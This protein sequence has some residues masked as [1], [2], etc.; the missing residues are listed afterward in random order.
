MRKIFVAM[1]LAACGEENTKPDAG[2]HH[3]DAHVVTV[4]DA[5]GIWYLTTAFDPGGCNFTS[6]PPDTWIFVKKPTGGY[7]ITVSNPGPGETLS[8]TVVDQRGACQL[9]MMDMVVSGNL[10]GSRT[11]N[12]TEDNQVV[13]G[14]GS[15]AVTNTQT[16]ATCMQ[17]FKVKGTKS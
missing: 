15:M 7:E 2:A 8:G 11:L 1:L 6:Q 5:S 10:R 14:G 9:V 12:L 3:P 16:G 13:T 17:T 4:C